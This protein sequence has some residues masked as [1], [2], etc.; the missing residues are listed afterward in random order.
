MEFTV[1]D[2]RRYA[3]CDCWHRHPRPDVEAIFTLDIPENGWVRGHALRRLDAYMVWLKAPQECPHFPFKDSEEIE[4]ESW[5]V[6]WLA[7]Q[8]LI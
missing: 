2:L 7:R 5:R 8:S 1:A 6:F 4:R 3:R